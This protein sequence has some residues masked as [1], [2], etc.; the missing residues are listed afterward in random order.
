MNSNSLE[1]LQNYILND[2]D[3]EDDK[4]EEKEITTQLNINIQNQDL[5]QNNKENE[6]EDED[7]NNLN[8]HHNINEEDQNF[9]NFDINNNIDY[10]NNYNNI[11]DEANINYNEEININDNNG[12]PNNEMKSIFE[13]PILQTSYNLFTKLRRIIIRKEN[14]MKINYFDKWQKNIK[15]MPNNI[16]NN[17][18]NNI[19]NLSNLQNDESNIVMNNKNSLINIELNNTVDEE[20]NNLESNT[21]ASIQNRNV[22]Q[23]IL[24]SKEELEHPDISPNQSHND[25]ILQHQNQLLN[26][27]NKNF[28]NLINTF[29]SINDMNFENDYSYLNNNNANNKINNH[30]NINIE[31]NDDNENENENDNE[32]DNYNYNVD[33]NKS[34]ENMVVNN[35]VNLP[36]EKKLL[37][38]SLFN[39]FNDKLYYHFKHITQALKFRIIINNYHDKLFQMDRLNKKYESILDEKSS[40][41]INKTDEIEDLKEKLDSLSKSL[42]DALKKQKTLN[43]IPESLCS[44]CGGSLEE[45]FT[46]E[47]LTENQKIIKEQND[48]IEKMKKELNELR[49]KYNY[50]ELRLKDLDEIKKEFE[51]LSG[52]LLRPKIENYTQTES[53]PQSQVLSSSFLSSSTTNNSN[54]NNSNSKTMRNKAMNVKNMSNKNQFGNSKNKFNNNSKKKGANIPQQQQK[55]VTNYNIININN[56]NNNTS[57][58]SNTNNFMN[59][60]N[61]NSNNGINEG[62]STMKFDNSILS[63]ELLN[64]NKE[65]NKLKNE[66]KLICEKNNKFDKEKKEILDK[67]KSKTE[68]CEKYKKE[69]AE[70]IILI[71]NSRYKNMIETENEN[72]KLKMTLEQIDNEIKNMHVIN[73]KNEQKIKE[74]NI[75]LEKMKS[76]INTY[77]SF[78]A[79]KDNLLLA[80]TKYESEIKRLKY[81]LEQERDINEKNKIILKN[82]EIQ[83]DKLNKEVSY[84]SSHINQ[85]KADAAKALEDAVEYQQIVTALQETVNEYKIAL[86]K[87]KQ[88]K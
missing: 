84:Y 7:I 58:M 59:S 25:V 35:F 32:N 15:N 86:N 10:S 19:N 76:I 48:V 13:N 47:A 88:N 8:N 46:S 64:L 51:N 26:S 22:I 34:N 85:Y 43:V 30:M 62:Y 66:N 80:N 9:H 38:L 70:L 82:S 28:Q 31:N 27:G 4:M 23:N 42:K 65:F 2:N 63:A 29:A 16:S 74:Q 79:Q 72:K 24:M 5:I 87:I 52:V 78:K 60:T 57:I 6:N 36:K 67:L 41:I 73:E 69:N 45:S 39:I 53:E 81:D 44:K 61:S 12:L 50:S 56:N 54:L 21:S 37:C 14:L 71:N 49:T 83:I 77:N 33:N 3:K 17:I 68:M 40:I 55:K 11:N 75:Q 18:S 20:N 1:M